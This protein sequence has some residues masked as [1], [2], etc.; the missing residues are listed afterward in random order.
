LRFPTHQ[1]MEV[2]KIYR[3]WF[4]AWFPVCIK[5]EWLLKHDFRGQMV[6]YIFGRMALSTAFSSGLR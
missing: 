4:S 5:S 3:Y 1:S 2:Y 6:Q